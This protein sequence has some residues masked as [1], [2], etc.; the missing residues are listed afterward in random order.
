LTILFSHR[1]GAVTL[2]ASRPVVIKLEAKVWTLLDRYVVVPVQV[3][4]VA[5]PLL[6]EFFEDD[7]G[8]RHI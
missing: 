2:I 7:I 4:L 8:W 5:V 3:S 1:L 6:T